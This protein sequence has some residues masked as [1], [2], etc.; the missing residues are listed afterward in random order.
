MTKSV[1]VKGRGGSEGEGVW[2]EDSLRIH[3]FRI[4]PSAQLHGSG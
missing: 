2:Q 1:K 4:L 3:D